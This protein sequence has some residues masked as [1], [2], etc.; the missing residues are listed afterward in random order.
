MLKIF[1]IFIMV[2]LAGGAVLSAQEDVEVLLAGYLERDLDLASRAIKLKQAEISAQQTKITNGFNVTLSTGKMTLNFDDTAAFSGE[3]SAEIALPFLNETSF[4]MSA[5]VSA[6]RGEGAETESVSLSLSTAILSPSAKL[7]K[8]TLLEAERELLEARRAFDQGALN[9]EKQFYTKLKALYDGTA[10]ALSLEDEAYN[11]EIEL[12]VARQQGYAASSVTYRTLQ[13][14]ADE[15]HRAAQEK[16]RVIEREL[17]I[18]SRD[19]GAARLAALPEVLPQTGIESQPEFDAAGEKER[20][21]AV[22]SANWQHFIGEERRKAQGNLDMSVNGGITLNN[23]LLGKRTSADAGLVFGWRGVDF[24]VGGA[25]PLSGAQ[26]SPALSL[27][28]SFNAA[29][30]RIKTLDEHAKKLQSAAEALAL[31][32]AG[33]AWEEK[34]ET[35]RSERDDLIWE[36]KRLAEQH[37]LYVKLAEDT[38]ELYRRG[39]AS[40]SEQRKARGSAERSRFNLLAADAKMRI[41]V[42]D[43]LLAFVEPDEARRRYD[44]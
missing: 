26:K 38:G 15:A 30:Q 14:E 3:P 22:E 40:D 36:K 44:H 29:T 13:L 41:H 9:A 18:F 2:L 19:C 27:S 7:R 28:L 4:K 35:M 24:T 31:S 23:S 20:F 33:R 42:I 5:P 6:R 32:Q 17:A 43:T 8:V 16:R 11:K 12:A 10:Q 21:T 39:L 25:L 37:E 34:V 1:P